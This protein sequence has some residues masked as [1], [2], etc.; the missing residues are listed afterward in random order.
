MKL[1]ISVRK[2]FQSFSVSSMQEPHVIPLCV[3]D[4]FQ[5]TGSWLATHHTLRPNPYNARI[6]QQFYLLDLETPRS[7]LLSKP[8]KKRE[9][10]IERAMDRES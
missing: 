10:E 6:H 8:V 5:W 1:G 7:S 2:Q 4:I 9:E 3:F